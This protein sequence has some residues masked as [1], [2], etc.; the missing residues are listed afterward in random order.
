MLVGI[1][2]QIWTCSLPRVSQNHKYFFNFFFWLIAVLGITETL[3]GL[4]VLSPHSERQQLIT[5][6]Q[7]TGNAECMV[8]GLILPQC[9]GIRALCQALYK[10]AWRNRLQLRVSTNT[11]GVEYSGQFAPG[12]ASFPLLTTDVKGHSLGASTR[13]VLGCY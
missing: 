12:L 6:C 9:S 11:F 13:V 7:P 4:K 8:G 3:R 2:L 10:V 5:I 1:A